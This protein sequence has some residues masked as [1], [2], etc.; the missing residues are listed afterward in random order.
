MTDVDVT[1]AVLNYKIERGDDFAAT[2]LIQEGDPAAPADVSTRTYT[3]QLRRT[4]NA[5]TAVADFTIDMSDA[6]NGNVGIALSHTDTEGLSGTY[7][8][9]FQQDTAGVIRT[10]V[11]GKF[12]I[13]ADVT[14]A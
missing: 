7:F 14:R 3:A 9:D 12:K 4:A 10:L 6:D 5:T 13:T 2:I 1:A 8:W 11:R